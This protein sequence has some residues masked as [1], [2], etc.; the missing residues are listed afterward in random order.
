MRQNLIFVSRCLQNKIRGGR[1]NTLTLIA[2]V[3]AL[4]LASSYGADAEPV[5]PAQVAAAVAAATGTGENSTQ[6]IDNASSNPATVNGVNSSPTTEFS[7]LPQST[8]TLAVIESIESQ[9]STTSQPT[10]EDGSYYKVS[11]TAKNNLD[12]GAPERP[13]SI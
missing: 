10:T 9:L 4:L 7:L 13:P 11:V 1:H 8:T 2:T 3:A 6:Q 12:H 5:A